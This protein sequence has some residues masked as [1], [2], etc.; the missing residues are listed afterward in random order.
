[1]PASLFEQSVA[2]ALALARQRT[3]VDVAL[4]D[5]PQPV[6]IRKPFPSPV[7]WRDH[8]IYFLMVDRFNNPAASPRSAWDREAGSRQGGTL[9]GVR[10]QLSYIEDLGAGAI[11]LTPVLKN[12]QQPPEQSHHGYGITD[13]LEI[14]PRFGSAAGQADA[15]FA[16]LVDEA[17]A[18]G[19]FVILDVVIN[20]SGDV[21]AYVV[22]GQERGKVGWSDTSY[23]V[24]W[25]DKN[26][27]PRPDWTELPRDGSL[28]RDAGVWPTE[29]QDNSVF[30]RQ[31][32]GG[33][34]KGDFDVLKEFKTDARDAFGD[35]PVW[36]RL[37]RAY[38]Y[39]IAR[40]DVDGFRIDTLKHVE[41]AF[42]QTFCNAMREFALSIGKANFFTF[43]ETK[44]NE[45]GLAAYT[46]RYTT[47]E[48]SQLGADASLDF[49]LQWKL[50]PAAKA[51]AAASDVE[52]VFDLRRRVQR[53]KNLLSSHG[54]ASR[55]FV[56]FLDCHD[57]SNR[58]LYPRAGGDLTAQLTLGLGCVFA[59]QGIPCL[60]YGTEQGLQGTAELYDPDYDPGRD[61]K[62]EHVREALWGKPGAFDRQ[63]PLFVQI[64][65][66][67]RLRADEP[68]LRY[69]RQYFRPVSG[70][71]ADFGPS[72]VRGGLIAFSRV[73]NDRE[74]VVV[75]N[76]STQAG[77]SGW[78]LVDARIND[79]DTRFDVV[80]SNLGTTGQGQ[81]FGGEARIYARDGSASGAWIRRVPVVLAPMEIQVLAPQ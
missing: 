19:L 46:G 15:E 72:T 24:H 59:L 30:R 34:V 36:N 5:R 62:P 29:L 51:L 81:P 27:R 78:V 80:Y 56:T 44:D 71:N 47:E 49:P 14:D 31:G 64:R 37:I 20:H 76:T 63:H 18:R 42:A 25:R 55:F 21:F 8:W 12:R 38:Q 32:E 6:A 67:A 26:G 39:V 48:D 69:G 23:P 54:D 13:F 4:P 9:A 10:A 17:H 58:F 7:D 33:P 79:D 52:D 40:Y 1:M 57:D 45:E 70:N 60:Y 61:G 50:G 73:L 74:V 16:R 53:E 2:D 35:A 28:H 66:L 65:T 43:G 68:G 41:R 11:W 3:V 22:D 77:F 75:A